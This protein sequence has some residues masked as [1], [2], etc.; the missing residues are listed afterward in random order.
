MNGYT[1]Y[2]LIVR[3]D[4]PGDFGSSVGM[5]IN[6][7]WPVLPTVGAEWVCC[8]TPQDLPHAVISR[9]VL[10][11]G[12]LDDDEVEVWVEMTAPRRLLAHLASQHNFASMR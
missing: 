2:G 9:V 8:R 3:S 4:P 12:I 6:L 7:G 5:I 1:T 11:G 10:G